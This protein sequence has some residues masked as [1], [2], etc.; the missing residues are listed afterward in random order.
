MCGGQA[1]QAWVSSPHGRQAAQAQCVSSPTLSYVKKD[2]TK[3]NNRNI[4]MTPRHP[5]SPPPPPPP[6]E[7]WQT[8]IKKLIRYFKHNFLMHRHKKLVRPAF[9]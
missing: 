2:R 6:M 4:Q 9:T 5:A 8:Q 7:N 3:V 1:V